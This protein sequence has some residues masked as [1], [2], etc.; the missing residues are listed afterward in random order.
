MIETTDPFV[1]KVKYY[2]KSYEI[3]EVF[4]NRKKA[5]QYARDMRMA[6]CPR[7]TKDYMCKTIVVDLGRDAKYRYGVFIAKG[8]P[9]SPPKNHQKVVHP[10]SAEFVAERTKHRL[11]ENNPDWGFSLSK[12]VALNMA[13]RKK[14]YQLPNKVYTWRK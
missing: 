13:G 7:L 12:T 9:F 1:K 8:E 6:P 14:L 11:G 4:S 2:N 10:V 3:Y 5:E